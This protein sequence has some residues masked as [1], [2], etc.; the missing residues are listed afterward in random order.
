MVLATGD[1]FASAK[2]DGSEDEELAELLDEKLEG[3]NT[4]SISENCF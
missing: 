1:F 2:E 3:E 4:V